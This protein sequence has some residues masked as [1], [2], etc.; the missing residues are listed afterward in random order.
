M[1]T[2]KEREGT[3]GVG[4]IKRKERILMS[5]GDFNK[6]PSILK[7]RSRFCVVVQRKVKD[8]HPTLHL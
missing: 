2:T 5:Q 1:P 8:E 7:D 6:L 4:R 3:K